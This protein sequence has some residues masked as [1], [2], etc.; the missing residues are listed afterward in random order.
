MTDIAE[1]H[2]AAHRF[3]AD[4][5]T[6]RAETDPAAN[7]WS[8]EIR[9]GWRS[10]GGAPNGGYL[11]SLA[12]AAAGR[13]LPGQEPFTATAHFL[14][15]AE[16]G[17]ADLDVDVV[18]TGR[19]KSTLEVRLSQAGKERVRVLTTMGARP[20]AAGAA[21]SLAAAAAAAPAIPRPD[22]CPSAPPGIAGPDADLAERFEYRIA[23][24]SRWLRGTTGEQARL[25]GWIRFADGREPDLAALPL[26]AD[27]FPPSV[28]EV[29]ELA[30]VP[31]LE[32]TVHPRRRPAPGWIQ[33]RFETRLVA[34]GMLEED[35]ML[36]DSK[37]D[38][39]A[40]SRQLA[41]LVP[42]G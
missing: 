4:I 29:V 5:A 24:E 9:P 31:T 12:L 3:D 28:Y 26:F 2:T 16:L 13:T 23:G 6:E 18:R 33:V 14:R 27:A 8:A 38:L 42:L 17:R 21:Q 39:V 19:V 10:I 40:M 37:G 35:G 30:L 7:R 25:E 22:R 41:L 34:D 11:L 36:W 15:P 32:L 1:Q 20:P